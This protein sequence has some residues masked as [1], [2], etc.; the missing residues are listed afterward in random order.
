LRHRIAI[1]AALKQY[2]LIVSERELLEHTLNASLAALTEVLSIASPLAFSSS[3]R[4]SG[5]VGQMARQ[6]GVSNRWE[7]ELA[8]MLSQIG[9]IAVPPD[10]LQK[11]SS[12]ALLTPEEC[13]THKSHPEIAYS[14]LEKIP[15][16]E[17]IAQIIRYQMEPYSFFNRPDISDVVAIGAQMIKTATYFDESVSMR[18]TPGGALKYMSGHP[19]IY[20]PRL[21]AALEGVEIS[22]V[23]HMVKSLYVR[24]LQL[25]MVLN[26][27]IIALTGLFVI[28][29]GQLV[30]DAVLARLRNFSRVPGLREPFSVLVPSAKPSAPPRVPSSKSAS[31]Y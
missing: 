10:I 7:F 23:D 27:D 20:Q 14:L 31:S 26:E 25:S 22:T 17:T 18:G 30:T 12:R 11:V 2:Q 16:M 29:R 19:E 3:S 21:V 8:A 4:I 9:C 13:K 1:E 15:R 24:D 6:L 28:P 5:Y